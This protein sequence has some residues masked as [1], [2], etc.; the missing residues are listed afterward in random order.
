MILCQLL[1]QYIIFSIPTVLVSLAFDSIAWG[2]ATSIATIVVFTLAA[3]FFPKKTYIRI[4][5]QTALEGLS[6][7]LVDDA[8]ANISI[9]LR[10]AE[11][12]KT[13]DRLDVE[14]LCAACDKV[15]SYLND[16]GQGDVAHSLRERCAKVA[17]RFS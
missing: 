10:E 2:L 15:A 6:Y 16:V 5:I 8:K 3:G 1:P 17:A 4:N 13:M 12:A 14:T 11:D 7:G 9:A